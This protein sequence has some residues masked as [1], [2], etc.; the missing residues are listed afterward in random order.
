MTAGFGSV[1]QTEETLQLLGGDKCP[2]ENCNGNVMRNGMI[3]EH[4]HIMVSCS[5]CHVVRCARCGEVIEKPKRG[6]YQCCKARG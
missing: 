4:G 5:T 3:A 6:K 2:T 1:R